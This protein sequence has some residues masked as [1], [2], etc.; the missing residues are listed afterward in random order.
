MSS[1]SGVVTIRDAFVNLR[2]DNKVVLK[3]VKTSELMK[4][5]DGK[6]RETVKGA[7]VGCSGSV[8]CVIACVFDRFVCMTPCASWLRSGYELLG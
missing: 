8:Q 7:V 2:K 5:R 3:I 6:G 1:D 4:V